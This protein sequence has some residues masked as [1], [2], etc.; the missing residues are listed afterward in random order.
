MT[1]QRFD[2][3]VAELR[4]ALVVE[5]VPSPRPTLEPTTPPVQP[6]I[7]ARLISDMRKHIAATE[8]SI[9]Q[10]RADTS[11]DERVREKLIADMQAV[12]VKTQKS[13]KELEQ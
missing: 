5:Q 10:L 3:I 6:A 2:Q 12:I 4:A 9:A 7:Q 8:R 1:P 11:T 13:I